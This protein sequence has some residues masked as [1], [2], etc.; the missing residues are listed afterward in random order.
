MICRGDA[1]ASRFQKMKYAAEVVRASVDADRKAPQVPFEPSIA[2]R[3]PGVSIVSPSTV[4]Q[5][6]NSVSRYVRRNCSPL[7]V[8]REEHVM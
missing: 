3:F 4:D 6:F 2:F 7:N 5:L 8:H 1:G